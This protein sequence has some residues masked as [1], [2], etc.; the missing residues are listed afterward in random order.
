MRDLE[1]R[2]HPARG[3]PRT[4]VLLLLYILAIAT[5]AGPFLFAARLTEPRG[6][7]GTSVVLAGLLL[8]MLRWFL[9]THYRLDNSGVTVRFLGLAMRHPW[10]RFRS[11]RR[12]RCGIF[13]SPNVDPARFDR[14]RGLFIV[15]DES[16]VSVTAPPCASVP[17]GREPD[18][19]RPAE[20]LTAYLEERIGG[21]RLRDPAAH[22]TRIH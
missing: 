17:G 18:D 13:L 2:T 22:S 10:S 4:T 12:E 20:R 1:V 3:R 15:L 11:F 16:S 21:S 9:P 5:A 6:W 14:L 8:A 19:G 7:L